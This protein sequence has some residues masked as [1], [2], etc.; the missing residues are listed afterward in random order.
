[1][2]YKKTGQLISECRHVNGLTQVQLAEK[3]G[4]SNRAVS[5]WECGIGFPD[6]SILEPLADA[7]NISVIELIHGER[8]TVNIENDIEVRKALR[9]IGAEVKKQLCRIRHF[10]KVSIVLLLTLFL[11]WHFF[12]FYVTNGDGFNPI[13]NTRVVRQG[14]ENDCKNFSTR[15]IYKIEVYSD[16][17]QFAVT[18]LD[19]IRNVLETLAK[20]EVGREYNDWGPNSLGHVIRIYASGWTPSNRFIDTED[21]C[22]E[23]TF[24]AFSV[25]HFREEPLR[26]TQYYY[27]ARIDDNEAWIAIKDI[28]E[29]YQ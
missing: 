15:G 24:P 28:L 23:L 12:E 7:L 18:D 27:Q 6:V 5:K 4:V 1:M 3:L 20:V 8:E 9:I 17:M 29:N 25:K 26:E 16:S 10:A 11:G 21:Y 22:I 2:D 19:E 13:E 14:Y